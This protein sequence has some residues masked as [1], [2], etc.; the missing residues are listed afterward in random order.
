MKEDKSN[1]NRIQVMLIDPFDQSLSYVEIDSTNL[2][3]FYNVMNCNCFDI[4][5][6]G[7][8]I[9]MYIDDEGLLKNNN[10]YFR[11]GTGNY[12]GRAI[13]AKETED[14]GTTD[15]DL[16]MTDVA[17]KLAWLPEGHREEPSMKFIPS[18]WR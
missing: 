9:I 14:G 17:D 5:S 2:D 16:F 13:L 8:G 18:T 1:E 11:L 15:V 6:L 7:G 4:V 3:D 10:R 12:A